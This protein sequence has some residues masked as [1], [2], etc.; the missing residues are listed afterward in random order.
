MPV[1]KVAKVQVSSSNY[2]YCS[3]PNVSNAQVAGTGGAREAIVK[4][5]LSKGH[6]HYAGQKLQILNTRIQKYKK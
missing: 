5:R 3:A 1:S 2:D 6:I 4:I